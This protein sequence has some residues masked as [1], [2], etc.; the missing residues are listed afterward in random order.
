MQMTS[1]SRSMINRLIR[2]QVLTTVKIGKRRLVLVESAQ[3][4]LRDGA[5]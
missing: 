5:P 2:D 4:L 1:L 3:R